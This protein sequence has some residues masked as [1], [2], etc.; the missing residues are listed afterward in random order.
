MSHIRFARISLLLAAVGLNA[1]PA[2]M[3]LAPVQ[4]AEE[5]K[6]EPPKDTVRPEIYK[7]I[8]PAQIKPLLDAKNYAEFQSRIDQAAAMPNI[9][10]YEDFILHRMRLQLAQ[11]QGNDEASVKELQ[12]IID[13]GHLKPEEKARFIEA[14]ANIYYSSLKNFDQAIV[15]FDKYAAETG[16]KAKFHPFLLRAYFLKNDFATTK[17]EVL[18]DIEAA[19]AANATPPKDTLLLLGNVAIKTKENDLYL[20]AVEELTR[21]YPTEDYWNDLLNRTRGKK[22]YAAQRLDLDVVRIKAVAAPGKMEPED[23]AEQAELAVLGGFFTEAKIAM[24]KGYPNGIPAGKDKAALEKIKASANKGAADDAK[25]ID[26]GIPAAQKSKDGV[27]LVNLG[28]NYVTLGQF[29]KGIDLMKQGIAKGVSKNPED[30][31]LRLGYALVM[32]GKKDEAV[33]VL[34]TITGNDGRSDLARYWIMYATGPKVAAAE[35]K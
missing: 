9:T 26:S 3:G 18:K 10:S 14:T 16:D 19:K 20:Q 2:I 17:T 27:G 34:K 7:L 32:A 4:A 13:S 33:E 29:D 22:G 24:D 25:N 8:D 28:Y 31:K 30:A 15:W 6:V 5:K 21:Y 1:A 12:A 11:A 23:Y 35:A